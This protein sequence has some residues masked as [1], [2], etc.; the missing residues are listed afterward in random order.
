[1]IKKYEKIFTSLDEMK[2]INRTDPYNVVGLYVHAICNYEDNNPN[3]L[4]E[5]IQYLLGEF[6]PLSELMKQN[7]KDRMLQNDKYKFIGK[8]Y[9][10]GAT[11]KND[12]TPTIPYEI[13]IK[14]NPYTDSEEGYKKLFL[15]SGG[16]D[17][18]RPIT[19]RLAKDGNYYLWSDSFIGILSDIRPIESTNPWA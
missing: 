5:M 11:P 18:D 8:S 15:K 4:Y 13:E 1:M 14:E 9:F 7:L 10:V 6:Q 2:G 17:S 12:Y 16:A 3:K 19:L